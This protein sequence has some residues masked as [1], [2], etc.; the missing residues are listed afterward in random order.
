MPATYEKANEAIRTMADSVL[1][2]FE[3]HH[4]LIDAGVTIDILLAFAERDEETSQ[5]IGPALTQ[6]GYVVAALTKVTG[7]KDRAKGC[8]DAEI[9][10][11]GDWWAD[12][13]R[14]E[15]IAL[16]DHELHHI[17]VVIKNGAVVR[18]AHSR[19]K[20]RLRKHD[21]QV[22]WFSV[23]AERHGAASI[24]C[25]QA[26]NVFDHYGQYFWP[27]LCGGNTVKLAKAS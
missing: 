12:H 26:Q 11:D 18:D 14:D 22:G 25:Q 24:E 20:L 15:Q 1:R 16:L 9:V 10:I 13:G 2:Q 5:P 27:A 23:I 6:G 17:A 21:V 8:A 3:S 7:L 4:P 19:P